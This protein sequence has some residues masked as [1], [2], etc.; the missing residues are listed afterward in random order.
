MAGLILW[1]HLTIAFTRKGQV[2]LSDYKVA[3]IRA[4]MLYCELLIIARQS[5]DDCYQR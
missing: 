1:T 5:L 2:I 3:V 4:I